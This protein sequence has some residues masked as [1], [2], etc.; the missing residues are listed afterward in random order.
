VIRTKKACFPLCRLDS[1]SS[2]ADRAIDGL[3]Q[4]L[5]DRSVDQ[6][7]EVSALALDLA[8]RRRMRLCR[9]TA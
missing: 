9:I 6:L 8:T 1:V 7:V 2:V 3:P 5:A 4:T